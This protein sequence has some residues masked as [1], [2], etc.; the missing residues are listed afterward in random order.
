MFERD[1]AASLARVRKD[2]AESLA[3]FVESHQ[4]KGC[5]EDRINDQR[6]SAMV[7]RSKRMQQ[8]AWPHSAMDE[9]EI[10]TP[11]PIDRPFEIRCSSKNGPAS[12]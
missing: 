12:E 8:Q 10:M 1:A 6:R 11:R 2:A 9:A 3:H 7:P 4:S 5:P